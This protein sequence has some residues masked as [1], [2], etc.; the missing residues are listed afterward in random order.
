MHW[1][2]MR[3]GSSLMSLRG[4]SLLNWIVDFTVIDIET[5]GLVTDYDEIIELSALRVRNNIVSDSYSVLVKPSYEI[6]DFIAELTGITNE[7]LVHERS[8]EEVISDFYNFIG[9][10]I[11]LGH[12]L[13]F[14]IKFINKNL[15]RFNNEYSGLSAQR[16]RQ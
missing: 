2:A 10:D 9:S 7:M 15:E 12:N 1:W 4:L 14:D 11:L 3:G 5:T 8:I 6:D 16:I 13:G